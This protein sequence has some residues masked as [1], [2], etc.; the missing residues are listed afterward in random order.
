[1]SLAALLMLPP[2]EGICDRHKTATR[3]GR[4]LSVSCVLAHAPDNRSPQLDAGIRKQAPGDETER[5]LALRES[6]LRAIGGCGMAALAVTAHAFDA[7]WVSPSCSCGPPCRASCGGHYMSGDNL[8][9]PG[10]PL[11]EFGSYGV[12]LTTKER[13]AQTL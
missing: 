7:W 10:M 13:C 6:Q 1:M 3:R 8:S 4:R 5:Y 2:V 11:E 9:L 12:S